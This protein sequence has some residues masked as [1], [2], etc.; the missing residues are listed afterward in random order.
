MLNCCICREYS[1]D[2]INICSH[3]NHSYCKECATHF[4]TVNLKHFKNPIVCYYDCELT[5]EQIQNFINKQ[6]SEEQTELNGLFKKWK[7]MIVLRKND[8]NRMCPNEDCQHV[9]LGDPAIPDIQYEK[10]NKKYCFE[11]GL[12]H[13]NVTC[14]KYKLTNLSLSKQ[15]NEFCSN[16]TKYIVCKKCPKCASY[17]QKTD[18]CNHMK[19]IK[20]KTDFCWECLKLGLGHGYDDKEH[21]LRH[22]KSQIKN[23]IIAIIIRLDDRCV[24]FIHKLLN[25]SRADRLMLSAIYVSGIL[26]ILKNIIME[27][28]ISMR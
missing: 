14:N 13:E 7:N 20:C 4:I 18:G 11:H 25:M 17:I 21:F 23:Y 5:N 27:L 2:V 16:I 12:I 9:Q 19:C 3:N 28:I 1:H 15:L 26:L 22:K 6:S 10:C 24:S 8:N